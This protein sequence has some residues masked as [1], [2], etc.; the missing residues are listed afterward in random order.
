VTLPDP[1]DWPTDPVV[2]TERDLLAQRATSTPDR[3]A[4]LDIDRG[5]RW[6]YREFDE[7]VGRLAAALEPVSPGERVGLLSETRPDFGTSYFASVRRGGTVVA[8]NTQLDA[9]RLADQARRAGVS[10]LV[11]T[12]KTA[13]LALDIAPADETVVSIDGTDEQDITT[14]DGWR[15]DHTDLKTPDSRSSTAIPDERLVLFTSGTTGDPKGVRLTAENLVAS[16]VGSARRLG[17][18]PDDRWLVCLPMYHTGGFA[19]L[20]RSTLYGTAALIQ[21]GFDA[22]ATARILR[23]Q[24]VTGVSLVPTMLVRL[25][26][27]DWTPPESLRFVLLGGAPP[28]A[29]LLERALARGVPVYPTYGLTET[30]S[31]VAT[32]TPAEVRADFETVGRPLAT[33]DVTVVDPESGEPCD[34]GATGELVVDGPVVGPGYLDAEQ[35]AAAM[36]EYGLHTGD[37]GRVDES[38]RLRIDGRIDD[39]IVTG[40]ENVAPERVAASIREIAGVTDAAVVGLPDEEWGERVAA[41]VAGDG[42]VT[43]TEIRSAVRSSLAAYEVPKTIEVTDSLPRTASGTIDREAVRDRLLSA[44]E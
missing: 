28:S 44:V 32:A 9:D 38:G 7:R 25:L 36:G 43:A 26:D 13:A 11:C 19:P 5:R 29:T 14:L 40:G 27:A 33:A 12:A 1:A 35:T 21:R 6:T 24:S 34:P 16:A 22:T 18:D 10:T 3:T 2:E 30:A 8:L 20:V 41:L 37:L 23:A 39:R 17:V 4:V 42:D 15:S 31:Q